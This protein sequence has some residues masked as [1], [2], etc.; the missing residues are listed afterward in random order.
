MNFFSLVGVELKKIR[1][2][3]ITILLLLPVIITWIPSV[4][5]AQLNFEMQDVGISPENNFFIQGFMGMVWFMLPATLIVCTVLL[6]QSERSNKAILKMLSLP[7]STVK[8]CLA[9][10]TVLLLLSTVQL[11][12]TIGAYGLSAALASRMQD[13]PFLLDPLYVCRTAALFY[14]AAIPMA[15]V[16]WAI[17]VLI[18]TPIFS[19]GIG[20]ASIVPAVLII[21]TKIWFAYPMCYPFYV[22]MTEYGKAAEGIF[23]TAIDLIPWLPTAA[24][25]PLLALTVSCLGFGAAER[26]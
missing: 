20:L 11:I 26:R 2:S 10:F 5:N 16:F 17:A 19:A 22:L 3:R 24:A 23:T 4:L 18:R 21:N 9:K 12:F 6:N 14:L 15:A 25:I 13:Y 7:V 8:L 1:R